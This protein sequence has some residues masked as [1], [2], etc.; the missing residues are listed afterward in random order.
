MSLPERTRSVL[1]PICCPRCVAIKT[2]SPV[3]IFNRIP[4]SRS[5]RDVDSIAGFGG[6][7]SATSP[8]KVISSSVSRSIRE[9]SAAHERNATAMT[10]QPS[11]LNQRHCSSICFRATSIPSRCPSRVSTSEQML[12]IC[13]SAPFVIRTRLAL[14]SNRML[15]RLREKSYGSSSNFSCPSET[16]GEFARSAAMKSENVPVRR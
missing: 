13:G 3:M 15:R 12:R 5:S 16:A 8:R 4:R 14:F 2:L 10:R 9:Q 6:S 7:D 11:E 1:S